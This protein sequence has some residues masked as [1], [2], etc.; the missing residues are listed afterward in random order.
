MRIIS[1]IT[2]AIGIL[3]LF[4]FAQTAKPKAAVYIK[5]NPEGRD[6][7]R[8]AV[9]TFLIK[10]Q[11]YQM[12]AVDAID[13]VAQEQNRQRGGSVSNEDIALLGRDAGAQYVCVVERSELD[14]T[15]YVS[16]SIV[17]VQSKIAE[18]SDISELP[19]GGRIIN[20]I[21]KQ[22]NTMLGISTPEP[23]PEP[24]TE[25]ATE[26]TPE[27]IVPVY[28]YT[29]EYTQP[30]K[31]N[32]SPSIEEYYSANS[33]TEPENKDPVIIVYNSLNKSKEE[34]RI[35][36]GIRLR[37]YM[38]Y[39]DI[40]K[41]SPAGSTLF[42]KSY[43]EYEEMR[44]AEQDGS[45][46]SGWFFIPGLTLSIRLTD[47]IFIA[48]ELNYSFISDYG[49]LY[50]DSKSYFAK[51]SISY[52]TIEIPVLLRYQIT[53]DAVINGIWDHWYIEAGFQWGFP[54]NS[55][56]TVSS[57]DKFPDA[58]FKDKFSNFRVEQDH[59]IILGIAGRFL[60]FSAGIRFTYP[61]TKLDKYGTI[62]APSIL[63]CLNLAYEF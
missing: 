62:A 3:C 45:G 34:P 10:S 21:E 44:Q 48:P 9:N 24:V 5:G 52:Q 61:L 43:A 40:T 55:E 1:K 20:L 25:Y 33:Y 58:P 60:N 30:K 51:V 12:I 38:V 36:L 2:L 19:R 35:R 50:G 49:F 59:S 46:K 54:V 56:A 4:A 28:T 42:D 7:L 23:E 18:L 63:N 14:G 15:S 53:P 11:K 37:G 31:Q 16:T 41:S 13:V 8:M 39:P 29:P 17:S 27:P 22:I 32:R 26:Y 6:A 47:M 57:G